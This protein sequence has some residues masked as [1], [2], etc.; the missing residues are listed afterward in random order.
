MLQTYIA[1]VYPD[2]K[3]RKARADHICNG[4]LDGQDPGCGSQIRLGQS[5]FDTGERDG[6]FRAGRFCAHCAQIGGLHP[7][8]FDI[9]DNRQGVC[10]PK[11]E[12]RL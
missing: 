12:R 11:P 7:D 6:E 8:L 9:S 5:Y 1:R 4:S 2:G 10:V 3:I